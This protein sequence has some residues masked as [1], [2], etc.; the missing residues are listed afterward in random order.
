MTEIRRHTCFATVREVAQTLQPTEPVFCLRPHV[1]RAAAARFV[2]TF[3]GRSLYAL[4]CNPHPT[5]VESLVAGGI[6]AFDTASLNEIKQIRAGWPTLDCY[7]MNPVKPRAAIS[8]ARHVYG[9]THFVVDHAEELRKIA[10]QLGRDPEVTVVVRMG[11]ARSDDAAFH[12]AAK[13]GADPAAAVSLLRETARLGFQPGLAFHVGS[14]CASPS[15]YHKALTAA[16][17]VIASA[18]VRLTCLDIGG[19]FPA[20][21]ALGPAIPPFD[22]FMAAI[23]AGLAELDL[24]VDCRVLAE[25]GRALVAEGCTLL[26]QVHLRKGRRLYINDG[27][28]GSLFEVMAAGLSLP[29]ALIRLDGA[30]AE[31]QACFDLAGPTC[32]S[33]DMMDGAVTLP[34]DVREGDWIAIDCM[35]AYSNAL[36]SRFN[37]FGVEQFVEVADQPGPHVSHDADTHQLEI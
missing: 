28:Y 17:D 13:F 11:T 10:D 24:P 29:G 37:G 27:V 23:R 4:K 31:T 19:G 12:L 2:R 26:V 21:Y 7:Y 34:N 16:R 30:V 33:L 22:D 15:A 5:V 1:I 18:G 25:P 6:D 35:G 8:T 32:D 20:P 9:V 36:V 14:Q 3:P